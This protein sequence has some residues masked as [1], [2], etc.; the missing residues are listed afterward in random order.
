[1]LCGAP[2]AT[3]DVWTYGLEGHLVLDG[4]GGY[5]SGALLT[6]SVWTRGF[7]GTVI[8]PSPYGPGALD[9][10]AFFA[11]LSGGHPWVAAE[12]WRL[13]AIVG[14]VLCAW[15]VHRIVTLRGGDAVAA[16]LAAVANPAVLIVLVAGIH[17]DALM[18]GLT[19]AGVAVGLSRAPVWGTTLCAL[20]VAVKSNALLAVGA[21]AWWAWGSRWRQRTTG[22]LV[23][24]AAVVGV[25]AV[26][27]LGTGG[28]FG[29]INALFSNKAIQGPWSIG[30]RFVGPGRQWPAS[31]I[32][33]AGLALAVALVMARRRSGDWFVG[34][35]WGFAV[36]AVTVSRPEPWYLAWA[37]VFLACGGLHSRSEQFGIVVLSAMM[38]GS[39]LPAGAYWWFC[40]VVLLAWL[41]IV[42]LRERQRGRAPLGSPG[43]TRLSPDVVPS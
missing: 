29:W 36:L 24:A 1:M 23:A 14:L 41:G 42:S 22:I 9:L 6:H 21:L 16:T 10:S 13:T 30:A 4:F 43:P 35:G 5:R 40:G 27:G 31:V 26:C 25:L 7:D 37:L 17:N 38:A 8:R 2:F 32:S 33:A 18:L 15:G 3:Q 11:K 20:G 34:L 12:L 19:V 39:V 28:G